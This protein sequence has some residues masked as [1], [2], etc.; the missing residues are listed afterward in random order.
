MNVSVKNTI[1]FFSI[2]DLRKQM[3]ALKEPRET[4]LE[5]A[6]GLVNVRNVNVFVNGIQFAN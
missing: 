2:N 4:S 3:S 5:I 6:H 1:T